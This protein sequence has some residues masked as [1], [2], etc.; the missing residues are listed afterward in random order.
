VQALGGRVRQVQIDRVME[1]TYI[2]TV[3]VEGPP[4]VQSST[5]DPATP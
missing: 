5:R 1:E 3:K 2:A 4:G